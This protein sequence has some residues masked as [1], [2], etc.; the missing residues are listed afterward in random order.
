MCNYLYIVH[1]FAISIPSFNLTNILLAFLPTRLHNSQKKT[2]HIYKCVH[3]NI[4]AFKSPFLLVLYSTSFS[5]LLNIR[6]HIHI[7][8]LII[9]LASLEN[10]NGDDDIENVPPIVPG[11][12]RPRH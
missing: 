8:S 11:L 6:T 12:T 10:Q 2:V 4:Y 7:Y 1:C 9:V 3:S 5:N